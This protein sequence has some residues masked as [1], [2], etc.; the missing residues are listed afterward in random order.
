MRGG[1]DLHAWK[2]EP[3]SV[4]GLEKVTVLKVVLVVAVL[5][6]ACLLALV[7]MTKPAEAA[8]PGVNGKIAFVSDRDGNSEIYTM[9]ADGSNPTRLT[10]NP[11]SDFS[12][13]WSA[14][15]TKIAFS[16]TREGSSG[17]IY[18]MNDDGTG[19]TKL[20]TAPYQDLDPTWSPDGTKIAYF[21]VRESSL[22]VW[23]VNADGT[24]ETKL[25]NDNITD[26]APDWSP[27]GTK[28]AT[29][30]Y[31]GSHE[32]CTVN[33][34]GSNRTRLTFPQQPGDVN[35][36]ERPEWSPDGTKIAFDT[37]TSIQVM[38]AD[39]TNQ[40]TLTSP[41]AVEPSWSPDGKKIAFY[42]VENSTSSVEIF[43][44]NV[45]G[46][47]K[48]SI[49]NN[50]AHDYSPD[51][52]PI[53]IYNFSGFY[54]PVDNLPTLNKTK[55]GKSIPI[56]FSLGGDHGLNI[57]ASGYPK[58]EAIPCDSTSTVDGIEETVT[59]KG[60]L[61]YNASTGRYE[62]DWGTS[63]TWSGCRQFVM[64]LRDGTTQRANFIFR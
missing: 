13:A 43:V 54:Q 36:Y 26:Q 39:G 47:G 18:V 27:D 58:S 44:I 61:S 59:G 37:A 41:R 51:W 50:P 6:A 55:P 30:C 7:E 8:F 35:G 63:S 32:I 9:N 46:T 24:G 40:T 28:I 12:P 34:D 23:V 16:S 14:D 31:Y 15:G 38:N 22:E 53:P 33:A 25:T 4:L 5:L 21:S 1:G 2:E 10:N 49:T 48:T 56:R 11:A 60:D 29:D 17:T 3:M 19:V 20:T 52:Q 45:D 42:S 62:Y 64:K 57:F